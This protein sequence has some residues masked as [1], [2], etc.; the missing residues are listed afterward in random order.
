MTDFIIEEKL[1]DYIVFFRINRPD[2]YNALNFEMLELLSSKLDALV[3]A[4]VRCLVITGMG[5]SFSSGV[6]LKEIKDFDP[7]TARNFS[8]AGHRLLE[9][10]ENF[11]CPVIAAVNG[12]A[13]G[14]GL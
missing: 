11:P 6:D 13:V 8:L 10:I 7:N 3:K 14:G 9:K 1:T 5:K 2:V 12:Y 4:D